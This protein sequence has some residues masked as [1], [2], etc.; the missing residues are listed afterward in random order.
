MNEDLVKE[1]MDEGISEEVARETVDAMEPAKEPEQTEEPAAQQD[2]DTS[3]ESTE[4]PALDKQPS[5]EESDSK[6]V[7]LAA[8]QEERK[9][10]QE[11]AK[12]AAEKEAALAQ[13]DQE[14]AQL[15]AMLEQRQHQAEP[16]A[17]QDEEVKASEP[18]SSYRRQL[19]QQAKV[20]FE[21]DHGRKPDI[22]SDEDD[23]A[24]ITLIANELHANVVAEAK[25]IE[26]E[27]IRVE[28]E[29]TKVKSMFDEFAAQETAKPDYQQ[30]WEYMVNR[31]NQLPPD[32]QQVYVG[33]FE[34]ARAGT[35]STQDVLTVKHFWESSE[36]LYRS[37]KPTETKQETIPVEPP[38][39]TAEQKLNEID[40]HPRTNQ[41]SGGNAKGGP[42][43]AELTRMLQEM[44]WDQIPAEYKKLLLEG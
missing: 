5:K 21:Q 43:Q 30:V 8:L 11:E 14:L 19:I 25:R 7:P 16:V 22:Y 41:L 32:L 35:G 6:T 24:E 12:R 29:R 31:V 4:E 27:K 42:T 17:K 10:R 15:R 26:G 3:P 40:K 23:A 37:N 39:K 34:R 20:M 2:T 28:Q 13:R 1:L 33:A 44:E 9:K 18:T 36:N 38:K